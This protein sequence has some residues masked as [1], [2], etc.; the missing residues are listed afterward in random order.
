MSDQP[1]TSSTIGAFTKYLAILG[2]VVAPIFVIYTLIKE[3]EPAQGT[4][5]EV[6]T[7]IKPLAVVEVSKDTGPHVD[8][9]GEEVV[10]GVCAACHVSGAMG[11]PKI[12]D[13]SAWGPRISQGYPTLIKHASEGIR[14]MP[15]R[16][17]NPDL[18]DN[19]IAE[20][21]AYMANESGAH[22]TAPKP[23]ADNPAVAK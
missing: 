14:M 9:S 3:P 7:R 18:S 4:A 19:E 5:A 11:S 13:K 8:K 2:G 12:G 1:H 22:F 16:G 15:A 23:V 10:K 20:A 6:E 17:G 21:V